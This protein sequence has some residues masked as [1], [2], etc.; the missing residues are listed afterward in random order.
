MHMKWQPKPHRFDFDDFCA[1]VK[2][3]QK[4]DLIDGVI[5]MASPDSWETSLFF[6]WLF[7]R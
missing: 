3:G 6:S 5:Y 1:L 4:A 7:P 2:D